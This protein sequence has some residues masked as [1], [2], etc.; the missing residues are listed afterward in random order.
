MAHGDYTGNSKAALAR[1]AA[2]EQQLAATRM[3]MVSTAVAE[4]HQGTIDL[5][6]EEDKML[7]DGLKAG[8][9]EVDG[10][11]LH[12]QDKIALYG[13]VKFRAS[14]DLEDVTVGQNRHFTLKAGQTYKAPRWV[15]QHLDSQGLVLH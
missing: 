14:E 12:D 3:S 2:E 7:H 10:V 13:P 8:N 9:V 11:T 5:C 4:A 6:T 1:A 15:A